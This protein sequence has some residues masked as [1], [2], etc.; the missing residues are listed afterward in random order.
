[1]EPDIQLHTGHGAAWDSFSHPLTLPVPHRH[2]PQSA[3]AHSLKRKKKKSY[4]EVH[5]KLRKLFEKVPKIAWNL[6]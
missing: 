4:V 1:M 6:S 3:H 2:H 5:I